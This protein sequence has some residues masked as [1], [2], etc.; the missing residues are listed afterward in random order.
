MNTAIFDMDGVLIDS[1]P[2]WRIAE[3]RVFRSVGIRLND[4]MCLQTMGYRTDEVVAYWYQQYPWKNK[5]LAEVEH[6]IVAEMERLISEQG[7]ALEGVY[8]VLTILK[9]SRFKIGLASSSALTLIN[10]VIDKLDIRQYFQVLHS[11]EDEE[12]GKPDPAVYLTAS[13]RLNSD[14][15]G[16]V[17]FEDSIPGV[18]AAK[19]AGMKVIAIPAPDQYNDKK[20]NEADIKLKSLKDFSIDM[21]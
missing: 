14:P 13:R 12:H 11:A 17:A 18:R 6:E 5:K 10:V 15:G 2:L 19:S 8:D 16:C 1:E 4:D 20:F 21:I 7:C 3:Q 9:Q